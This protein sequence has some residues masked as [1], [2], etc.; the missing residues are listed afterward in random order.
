MTW[1]ADT[2]RGFM[3]LDVFLHELGHHLAQQYSG[4]RSARIARTRE[5]E[6]LAER[7]AARCRAEL[8]AAG[9]P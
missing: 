5:H 1:P 3:L 9:I 2:L 6:S 7:F 4:K 8:V